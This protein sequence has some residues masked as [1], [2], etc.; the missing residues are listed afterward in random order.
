[1]FAFPAKILETMENEKVTGFSGVPS[2][3][4]ILT[5]RTDFLKRE[6]PHLRYLTQAGGAMLPAL[7]RRINESIPSHTELF[8]MYGQTEAS[9]RLSYLPPEKLSE[10][11]GSIG[12]PIPG[13]ELFLIDG[14]IAAT[15]D[16]IMHA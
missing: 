1:M 4:A 13:V 3:Y 2:H 9:A 8:V 14:E 10:K 5:D 15:G 6:W 7:T 11:Y 12:I 16:N